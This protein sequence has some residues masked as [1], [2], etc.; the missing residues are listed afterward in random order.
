MVTKVWKSGNSFVVSL[1]PAAMARAN[2]ARDTKV[3]VAYSAPG[4]ITI[5]RV[6]WDVID[7]A[8]EKGGANES[9]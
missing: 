8:M 7:E 2:L 6:E 9:E 4:E 1:P 5:R 3:K